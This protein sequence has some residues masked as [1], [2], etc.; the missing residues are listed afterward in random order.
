MKTVTK[1]IKET[2]TVAAVKTKIN[3]SSSQQQQQ[4]STQQSSNVHLNPAFLK[5]K[6]ILQ[7]GNAPAAVKQAAAEVSNDSKKKKESV[8]LEAILKCKQ[9]LVIEGSCNEHS[10]KAATERKK[11]K[12][13]LE[14]AI[15]IKND[16]IVDV[17]A[18]IK[19]W[20]SYF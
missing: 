2:E 8:H 1:K 15:D 14:G 10:K 17:K 5:A 12:I 18:Q 16:E 19:G 7:D 6:A 4:P 11:K 9:L 13:E 3:K 20:S